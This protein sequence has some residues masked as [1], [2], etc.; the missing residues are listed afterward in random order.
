M[1]EKQKERNETEINTKH[2]F[3]GKERVERK[4]NKYRG[5]HRCDFS[6]VTY[7]TIVYDVNR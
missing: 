7:C 3:R 5:V 1:K 2:K 4:D 6:I